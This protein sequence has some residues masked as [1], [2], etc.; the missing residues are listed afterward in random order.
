M[1]KYI[2]IHSLTGS[3][4]QEDIFKYI[5]FVVYIYKVQSCCSELIW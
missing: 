2:E 4:Y 3:K 5:W 1:L